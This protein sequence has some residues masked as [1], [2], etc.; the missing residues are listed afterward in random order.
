MKIKSNLCFNYFFKLKFTKLSKQKKNEKLEYHLK[1]DKIYKY[2]P[3]NFLQNWD[4]EIKKWLGTRVN[5]MPV[6]SG[7]KEQII[8]CLSAFSYAFLRFYK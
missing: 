1:I 8:A 5:A 7:K 2:F 3:F 6:D 4:K